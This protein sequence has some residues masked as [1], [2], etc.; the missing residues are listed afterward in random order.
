MFEKLKKLIFDESVELEPQEPIYTPENDSLENNK[1]LIKTQ[2]YTK[3]EPRVK[4]VEIQEQNDFVFKRIDIDESKAIDEPIVK[5]QD[6]R[7]LEVVREKPVVKPVVTQ[8]AKPKP[9]PKNPQYYKPRVVISPMFG[10]SKKEEERNKQIKDLTRPEAPSKDERI[11][12]PM[13]GVVTA[14]QEIVTTHSKPSSRKR[15]QPSVNMSLEEM[16]NMQS[17][18]ELEFT[19]FDVKVDRK[20]FQSRENPIINEDSE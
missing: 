17:S 11:I 8:Q 2:P 9:V 14:E 4:P 7:E 16:L 15:K 20:E 19:L 5:K 10:V 3:Q 6:T 1:N 12:S 13:Y 18:D